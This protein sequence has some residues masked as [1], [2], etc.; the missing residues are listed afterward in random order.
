MTGN[1]VS[2]SNK[3]SGDENVS[4]SVFSVAGASMRH[5]LSCFLDSF[6]CVCLNCVSG[7][8]NTWM[9]LPSWLWNMGHVFTK[10]PKSVLE[11]HCID[12][13]W[14]RKTILV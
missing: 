8:D 13:E 9:D 5:R 12:R 14:P 7:R 1:S 2:R 11:S 4:T 3:I 6:C 10:E